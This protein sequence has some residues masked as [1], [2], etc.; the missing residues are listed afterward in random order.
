MTRVIHA[1]SQPLTKWERRLERKQVAVPSLSLDSIDSPSALF[2]QLAQWSIAHPDEHTYY[3]ATL[4][5][6]GWSRKWGGWSF[7]SPSAPILFTAHLDTVTFNSVCLAPSLEE[8]QGL[9]W[10]DDEIL[11]GDDRAGVSL[12]LWLAHTA[13]LNAAFLLFEGE[14]VGCI[15]SQ[16]FL[17]KDHNLSWLQ[18]P[19]CVSLDRTGYTDIITH[20]M[21]RQLCS[22]KFARLLARQLQKQ[23]LVYEPST[24][25]LYT[26][27][28]HFEGLMPQIVNLSVGYFGSHSIGEMQDVTYLDRL[29]PALSQ[30][31][32]DS[33]GTIALETEAD[34]VKSPP[35]PSYDYTMKRL[36]A[37]MAASAKSGSTYY[38][39]PEDY[40]D[41]WE[42]SPED[43]VDFM[44]RYG[45]S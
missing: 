9:M 42:D 6:L 34:K 40:V 33:L 5:K 19:L 1:Q 38:L 20:Q 39:H 17:D 12:I 26:D 14:E 36:G 22:T 13:K 25:G 44:N 7:G 4:A 2:R 29:G 28:K 31:P 32:W 27:S 30:L 18:S 21:G 16:H 8:S 35:K 11:G 23:G 3:G 45:R 15:G 43:T 24:A 41:P 37:G 10:S